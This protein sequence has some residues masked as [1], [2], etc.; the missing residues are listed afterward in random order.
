MSSLPQAQ[1]DA[2]PWQ[3]HAGAAA[4]SVQAEGL[5]SGPLPP[6]AAEAAIALD[7]AGELIDALAAAG[8]AQVDWQWRGSAAAPPAGGAQARWQGREAQARLSLPWAA[9]RALPSAPDVPGLQ[10]LPVA[11]DCVLAQWRFSEAEL[12][13]L[14][15][16][17]LVLL[18]EPPAPRP[19][20]RAEP[21]PA[22]AAP[23]Q[24]VARWEQPVALESV[25]GWGG[26]LPALPAACLL[27]DTA[28][29]DVV[30][31]RGRLLPWGSGQALRVE[32]V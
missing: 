29:P 9:L 14:E 26:A 19:R 1:G 15:P 20:A 18:D 2:S 24:L 27:V 10:W 3:F 21:P 6:C 23:W 31:A 8:L 22:D 28:R 25:M 17:G 16:G 12:A 4:L 11:A 13:A 32:S 7:L 30:R 5:G